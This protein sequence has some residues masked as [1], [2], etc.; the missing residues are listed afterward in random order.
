MVRHLLTFTV[1]VFASVV[2]TGQDDT[3]PSYG[4]RFSFGASSA[5]AGKLEVSAQ[6]M[7]VDATTAD[8]AVT[9]QLPSHHYIYSTNPSFGA[10]TK[11]IIKEPAGLTLVGK[12]RPD[13]APESKFDPN[14][15]QIVEKFYDEVTWTRRVQLNSGQLT[16][17]FQ[18]QGELTGQYCSSGDGGTCR[19]IIPAAK[20]TASLPAGF[21]APAAVDDSSVVAGSSSTVLVVPEMRLSPGQQAPIRFTVSLAPESPIVGQDVTLSIRADIDKPYHTYSVTQNPDVLGA[22]PTDISLTT[23]SGLQPIGPAFS[24]TPA[25]EKK[26]GLD[27]GEFLELHHGSVEWV[28]RF[29]VTDDAVA[30][31]GEILFQ[32]CTDTACLEV[33][34]VAFAV[35]AGDASEIATIPPPSAPGPGDVVVEQVFEDGRGKTAML[36]FIL[37]AV[38]F[39]FVALLT[40]CV[41]PMIP[42]TISYFLKQGN[43]RPGATIKLALIYC[44]GIIG[45]F[46]VLGLLAAVIFGP[47]A[48]NEFANNPWLNLIFAGVFVVFALMLMGMFEIRVP[49]WILTWSSKKQDTGG[50][51]GVLFMALTFT[52][53]S[54][55]CTFAFVGQ[56]LVWASQGDYLMPVV[57]M[58]AFSTAFASPFFLLALF[59]S[60]LKSMPKSGGWM[61]SVKVTMGLLELAIVSKFLSIADTGF[62]A[63]GTPQFLDFHMVMASWIAVAVVTG[64]YLL[65]VFRMPHDSPSDTIGPVRCVFSI[66]FLVLAAY[67]S[68]GLFAAD[69]PEGKVWKNLAAFASPQIELSEEEGGYFVEHDGLKYSL[70]FDSAVKTASESNRPMFL[71]FTGVNCPNCR[72]M[73]KGVMATAPVHSIIKDLVRVQLY[74]DYVP[75]VKSDPVEHERVLGRNRSLQENWFGTVTIPAYVI[76]TPDGQEILSM[77]KGLD[78]D[79]V[80]FQQFLE[81]GLQRWQERQTSVGGPTAAIQNASY[82][83]H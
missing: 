21:E 41:F 61:N 39:G 46:T 7:P 59:P 73:E 11:I 4:D 63:T 31:A 48:I 72:L 79:G 6:L 24:A 33:T 17:G 51:V 28:R 49:S 30:V 65:N 13:R 55:T 23:V 56:L 47:T 50:V 74:V 52:L 58:I 66:S 64:M 75:G 19:P 43:E 60:L 80:E 18:V 3:F 34:T 77:F 12:I 71:D 44:G 14:F 5:E 20:F 15:Q 42:V 10:A 45:A 22:T 35:Q 25:A 27:E 1:C 70:D 29:T 2:A 40:P 16:P 8:L 78:S 69:E 53:V 38:G 76:A 9:V 36:P 26:P 68:M 81:A 57:G 37:S 62:S 32:I 83:T 82:T 67:I 54:F